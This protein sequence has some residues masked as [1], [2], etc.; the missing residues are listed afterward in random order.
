MTDVELSESVKNPV[1]SDN[2]KGLKGYDSD[3]DLR[4]LM[5]F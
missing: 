4:N 3:P 2:A 1:S 5:D